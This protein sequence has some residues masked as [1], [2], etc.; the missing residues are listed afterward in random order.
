[1]FLQSP[2][3]ACPDFLRILPRKSAYD[4]SE[5]ASFNSTW[6]VFLALWFQFRFRFN[7][8]IPVSASVYLLEIFQFPFPF[9]NVLLVSISSDLCRCVF[10]LVP[11]MKIRLTV[12]SIHCSCVF[13]VMSL[14]YLL[15]YSFLCYSWFCSNRCFVIAQYLSTFYMMIVWLV[16]STVASFFY[17][18]LVQCLVVK[19]A[20]IVLLLFYTVSQKTVQICS[21]Q[22][23]VP[24]FHQFW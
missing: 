7:Y 16:V 5:L 8:V 19:N 2:V 18:I 17:I 14:C 22:S 24:N 12:Q 20:I 10:V 13:N 4:P 23:F 1:M 21:C 3:A 15:C 6:I 11:L 9:G